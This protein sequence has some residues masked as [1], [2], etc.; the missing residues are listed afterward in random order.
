M[1]PLYNPLYDQR[2]RMPM[3]CEV[4]VGYLYLTD[5]Q[6]LHSLMLHLDLGF[7]DPQGNIS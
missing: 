5:P 7:R 4:Q 3:C 6:R 1:A 2:A